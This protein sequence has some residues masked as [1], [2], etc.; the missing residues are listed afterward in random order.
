MGYTPEF[1]DE[2]RARFLALI[3]G[4][5]PI[6]KAAEACGVS[7]QAVHVHRQTDPDFARLFLEARES[8]VEALEAEAYRRACHG[9]LREKPIYF[10]GQEVGTETIREYSDSLLMFLLRAARPGVYRD[11]EPAEHGGEVSVHVY[12]PPNQREQPHLPEPVE[13]DGHMHS[14]SH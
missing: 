14:T 7:R 8:A 9:T 10:R 3:S 11:R 6:G 12:L 2:R 5:T 1:D 4:A 13:V